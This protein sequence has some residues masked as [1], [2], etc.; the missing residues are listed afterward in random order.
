MPIQLS[1]GLKKDT[2]FHNLHTANTFLFTFSTWPVLPLCCICAKTLWGEKNT[3]QQQMR[4]V[5]V[6]ISFSH[7][8]KLLCI[9][10]KIK[11]LM[12]HCCVICI[13]SMN[14]INSLVK[15][16]LILIKFD[17]TILFQRGTCRSQ[18]VHGSVLL[19]RFVG[20]AE[21]SLIY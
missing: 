12:T 11:T 10:L 6:L 5:L 13:S 2:I 19:Q 18:L 16:T 9:K 15:C 1:P 8:K 17:L 3:K 4:L 7:S 21:R 14:Y 20:G